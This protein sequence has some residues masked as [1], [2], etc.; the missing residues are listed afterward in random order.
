MSTKSDY[1]KILRPVEELPDFLGPRPLSDWWRGNLLSRSSRHVS[2]YRIMIV[3]S[4]LL[5]TATKT[6]LTRAVTDSVL[7]GMRHADDRTYLKR[8]RPLCLQAWNNLEERAKI[9]FDEMRPVGFD[10]NSALPD[11]KLW[12]QLYLAGRNCKC[13]I[14]DS[15]LLTE[16][17]RLIV[18][19]RIG[20]VCAADEYF[21]QR[22]LVFIRDEIMVAMLAFRE[23]MSDD[24]ICR[25]IDADTEKIMNDKSGQSFE[26]LKEAIR[27]R[28][29]KKQHD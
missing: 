13:R 29:E 6:E 17:V 3:K 26:N 12:E 20:C 24:V 27:K 18:P 23:K 7:A 22:N 4:A 28:A 25:R 19:D 21:E 8:T 5:D 15:L 9:E 11:Q 2:D 10:P 16:L 1:M 14:V